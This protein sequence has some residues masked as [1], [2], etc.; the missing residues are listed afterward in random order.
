MEADT[1]ATTRHVDRS[2][3][4]ASVWEEIVASG[5]VIGEGDSGREG[6]SAEGE[7]LADSAIVLF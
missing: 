7:D 6:A 4:S 2:G 3:G 5:D 1:N